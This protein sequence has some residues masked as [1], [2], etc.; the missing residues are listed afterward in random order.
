[1]GG[2]EGGRERDKGGKGGKDR[3]AQYEQ[4]RTHRPLISGTVSPP[5]NLPSPCTHPT[6][7]K[8]RRKRMRVIGRSDKET[9]QGFF[10]GNRACLDSLIIYVLSPAGRLAV[11]SCCLLPLIVMSTSSRLELVETFH[12]GALRQDV[13]LFQH[14]SGIRIALCQIPGPLC[15]ADIVIPTECHD[16]GVCVRKRE[17]GGC[18]CAR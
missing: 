2:R 1:M 16:N 9:Q 4:I 7:S 17:G 14:T 18:L 6:A 3:E 12:L 8:R 5:S 11:L 10:R 15:Q 13:S